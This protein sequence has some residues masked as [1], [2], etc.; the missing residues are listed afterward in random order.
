MDEL[1]IMLR[2]VLV[3]IALALPGFILVKTELLKKEQS[4]AMAKLLV[5][6]G[7]PMMIFTGMVNNV[8]IN[9]TTV[10]L[11]CFVALIGLIYQLATFFASKPLTL[12]EKDEKTRG[13][14]RFSA[15]FNNNG[16]LGIPLA[17]AVFG[18][19]SE[20]LTVLIVINIVTNI[21]LYTLG[22]YLVS[23]DKSKISWK[24]AL[25]NPVLIA[26][27]AG[28]IVNLVDIKTY[29]PEVITFSTHFSN[30]VTPVSMTVL[31]MK[32]GGIKFSSLFKSRK[33][34]YVAALKLI[35]FPAVIVAALIAIKSIF[36]ESII[37]A[38]VVM[39]AF[40]AFGMPTAGLASTF[41]DCF[42]GDTENAVVFTLGTTILSILTIP[43]LYWSVCA[44]LGGF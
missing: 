9:A 21:L 5:Y 11:I 40:I 38:S 15:A 20:I 44:A 35:V 13:M 32:L 27:L 29:V 39:G 6:V 10:R 7:L 31:G 36:G 41:A 16:F 19:G 8:A 25:L 4:E 42:G 17:I 37:N 30:I 22:I 23:G 34:Y 24:K 28:I 18:S 1:L 3:F 33:L 26:F 43:L 14:M 12:M 2:N